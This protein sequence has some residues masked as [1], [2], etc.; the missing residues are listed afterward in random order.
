MYNVPRITNIIR[1]KSYVNLARKNHCINFI[2]ICY[3]FDSKSFKSPT[4]Q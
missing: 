3:M 4:K 2:L 1:I